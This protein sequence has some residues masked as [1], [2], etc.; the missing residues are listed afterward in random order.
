MWIF[1]SRIA[2]AMPVQY[3]IGRRLVGEQ[4]GGF[5]GQLA[6]LTDQNAGLNF[7]RFLL[8]PVDNPAK[9]D[10]STEHFR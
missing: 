6:H 8:I 4:R 5:V 10:L 9:V 7:H 1:F 3:E 2:R